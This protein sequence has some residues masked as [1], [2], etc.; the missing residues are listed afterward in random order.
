MTVTVTLTLLARMSQSLA[1][2][3]NILSVVL[4]DFFGKGR[5]RYAATRLLSF[6]TSLVMM[7]VLSS[8]FVDTD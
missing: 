5:A 6:H 4:H 3:V 1:A 2:T 8:V 7:P